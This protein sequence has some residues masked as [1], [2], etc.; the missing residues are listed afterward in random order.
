[1]TEAEEMANRLCGQNVFEIDG[2]TDVEF[3]DRLDAFIIVMDTGKR[4]LVKVSEYA[5][6]EL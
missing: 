6:E 4:Y 3:S 5:E 2:V 1:M